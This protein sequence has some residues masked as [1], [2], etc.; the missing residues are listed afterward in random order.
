M[1]DPFSRKIDYLRISVTDRCNLRCRYCMPEE[2]VRPMSHDDILSFEEIAAFTRIAVGIGITKVRLTGGEPL[3]RR[4]V[5]SLVAQLALIEGIS[6]LAMTTNGLLLAEYAASLREAGLMRINVSL[7]TV[8]R[9]RF[10]EITRRDELEAVLA[11]IAEARRV[12]FPVKI[13]TVIERSPEEPDAAA[14]AVWAAAEGLPI[15]FIRQ[16]DLAHGQFYGVIGGT[17]GDCAHCNRIRLLADGKVKP[18]LFSDLGF[19]VRELG[20]E[21]AIRRAIAAKPEKGTCNTNGGFYNIGG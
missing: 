5:V 18:C 15:R 8:D 16:M 4:G 20:A 17:G 6:D 1:F 21:E 14:V 2:G 9:D 10:R 11:G 19:S 13:N 12:G 7:D 3:V